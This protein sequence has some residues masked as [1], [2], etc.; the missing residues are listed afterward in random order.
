MR[1]KSIVI[2]V[3]IMVFTLFLNAATDN[4]KARELIKKGDEAFQVY[5][6]PGA[7]FSYYKQA[8]DLASGYTKAS[9]LIYTAYMSHL[10]G[11]K[12]LDYQDFIK[13]AL[14]IDPETKLGSADYQDSFIKIVYEIKSTGSVAVE[15]AIAKPVP[16]PVPAQP[17]PIVTK[18]TPESVPAQSQAAENKEI[19]KPL[20]KQKPLKTKLGF[21]AAVGIAFPS[22]SSLSEDDF[23]SAAS[24]GM[25]LAYHV[26]VFNKINEQFDV[27]G[28]IEFI[29]FSGDI[30]TGANKWTL[31]GYNTMSFFVSGRYRF[32]HSNLFFEGGLGYY[33]H[34]GKAVSPYADPSLPDYVLNVSKS[35]IGL[36]FGS[37]YKIN[38]FLEAEIC[39]NFAGRNS[40]FIM[41]GF[42][43]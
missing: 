13:R 18:P 30:N 2:F 40:V 12:I 28:G 7:A 16:E 35:K 22:G 23:G 39:A 24:F 14:D 29:K 31:S 42:K 37:G 4:T 5:K 41:F 21:K 8:I 11:D 1:K 17:E 36:R 9:A 26:S 43:I 38:N 33:S 3:S 25:G 15:P 6:N 27:S 32:F 34:K 20:N 10:L 19:K